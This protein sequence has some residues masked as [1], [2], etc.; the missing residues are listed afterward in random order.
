MVGLGTPSLC[1]LLAN[2]VPVVKE[3]FFSPGPLPY[4]RQRKKELREGKRVHAPISSS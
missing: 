3:G 2:G 4:S 1:H